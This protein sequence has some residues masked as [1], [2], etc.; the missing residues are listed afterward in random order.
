[1]TPMQVVLDASA[2][3]AFLRQEPGADRVDGALA[4]A[5]ITSVNWAEVVQTSLSA[6]VEVEGLRGDLHALGFLA[7]RLNRPV[8]TC[9]RAWAELVLPL[10]I[11]LLR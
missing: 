3:L 4:A 5:G 10:E 8:L 11:Q 1:M 7:L 9:A 6:G 2:L